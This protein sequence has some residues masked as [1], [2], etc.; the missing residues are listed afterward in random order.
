MYERILARFPLFAPATKRLASLYAD[1]LGDNQKAYELATKARQALPQDR[2]VAKTLGKLVYF[3]GDFNYAAQLLK[4]CVQKDNTDA[5]SYYY[6]GLTH[7]KLKQKAESTAAL[8]Q[9]LALNGSAKFAEDARRVLT[10]LK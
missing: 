6:L 10:E 7:F 4:E 1:R 5:E 9:A 8:R 3:R 2:D